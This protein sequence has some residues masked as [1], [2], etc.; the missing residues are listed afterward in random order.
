KAN[1]KN[2]GLFVTG[3]YANVNEQGGYEATTQKVIENKYKSL[4]VEIE[5]AARISKNFDLRG[6]ITFTDAKITSDGATKDNRPRRQAPF[7][8]NIVP[9]Y[10]S[11]NFSIGFT[12]IGTSSSYAQD[13]NKLKF[14]GYVMINP[15]V[16]YRVSK[17]A[18]LAV[19]ANNIGNVLGI[20]ESE[21]GSITPNTT[22]IIRARS[23]MGTTVSATVTFNF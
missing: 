7:I 5:A 6:G 19:N 16:N 10:T 23:I 3:F 22:N 21:E 2:L 8:F 4:G 18:N 14:K 9:T 20:T 11:N 13:D 15:F 1:Y 17:A 12:A